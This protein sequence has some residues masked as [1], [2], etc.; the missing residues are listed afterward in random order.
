MTLMGM[1]LPLTAV[2]GQIASG[3][4]IIVQLGRLR[5]KTR[6]LLEVVEITGNVDPATNE[7]EI[8]PIF[9]FEETGTGDDG[10]IIG[11]WRK[12]NELQNIAKLQAAGLSI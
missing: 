8:S 10:K 9:K 2:R 11:M 1:D 6:K 12:V 3:I 4:D 7:I 5:D